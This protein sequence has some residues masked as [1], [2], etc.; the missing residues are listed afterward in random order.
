M[1]HPTRRHVLALTGAALTAPAFAQNNAAWSQVERTARGQTVYFNAWGGAENIN[2]Y[3][4]WAAAQVQQSHG[5]KVEH[6][7]VTDTADVVKRVRNEKAA[8]KKDGTVDL[9]WINGENFLAMK[10]EGLLFGPFA[11]KLPSYAYVDTQGKPTTR[12]DFSEPVD[13]MEAPWGMAQLTFMA[14]SKRVPSP[15]KSLTEL[16]AFAKANPGRVTYPRPP[17]FHGTTF[18]KQVLLDVNADRAT[19]YKPV[20]PEAFAKATAPLWTALDALHPHLWRAGKQFPQNA[21]AVRQMMADGELLL[22]L[23]FNPNDAANEIAAKRLAD[24]VVSYQF[25][26]GTIGNTHFLAIPV[27]ARAAAGA[28]VFANFLLSPAAQARKA[29]IAV[30]GDPTVLALHKL[31]PAERARFAAKPLP[32]Q[33]DISAPAIPEPHGSWVDLLEKEWARRY[34]V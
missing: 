30:W 6:V 15:P 20:T 9:V 24:S 17:D 28:Q 25:S 32:G 4:Q 13:G 29:D 19:L 16:L 23:T 3:I 31:P 11:E 14:D 22:A 10:R 34:G 5:V 2:A 21:A 1:T 33:V 8:G 18:V 27:N 7:K 12:F 26:S